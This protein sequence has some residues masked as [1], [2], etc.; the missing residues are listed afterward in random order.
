MNSTYLSPLV[1][2]RYAS[3]SGTVSLSITKNK[4][5]GPTKA[6]AS[7][8]LVIPATA[9]LAHVTNSKN[10]FGCLDLTHNPS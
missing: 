10:K 3:V 5:K 2:F 4:A 1:F 9:K 7:L 6:R 8:G